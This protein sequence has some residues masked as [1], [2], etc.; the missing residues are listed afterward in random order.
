MP[1]WHARTKDLVKGGKLLVA[2][3]APEQHGDR[4]A[5]FL[6]WKGMQDMPVMLDSFNLLGLKAV[7]TTVLIDESGLIRFRNPSKEELNRF[8]DLPAAEVGTASRAPRPVPAMAGLDQPNLALEHLMTRVPNAPGMEPDATLLFQFGVAF[9]K[10]FDSPLRGEGDFAQAVDCWRKALE[11]DPSNYIWRRRLQQYGPRLDK[12]YPFYNWI[13]QARKDITARGD[14]PLP[15]VT[16]PT[17]AEIA[18][19]A[20]KSADKEAAKIPPHPD[21]DNKLPRETGAFFSFEHTV[22]PHTSKPGSAVRV[23][24]ETRPLN[25]HNAKWNDEAGLSSI[26]VVSP[27]GWTAQPAWLPLR[28]SGPDALTETRRVEFE[29]RRKKDA[30]SPDAPPE[31]TVQVFTHVCHGREGTCEF[32]RRD[33][34]IVLP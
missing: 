20:G 13:V 2:G 10:R 21:P 34:P 14:T 16:E 4:M 3:L 32:R 29:L 18:H 5:L 1:G 23:F 15:L 17:G 27:K 31:C 30:P 12:P 11:L 9:R 7:P 19:P 22:V 33:V 24:V 8:L 26:R 6:Q 25:G 28:P